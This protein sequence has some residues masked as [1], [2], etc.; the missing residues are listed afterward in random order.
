MI[1]KSA[2]HKID[3]IELM[4]GG[5]G[6]TEIKYFADGKNYKGR[7]RLLAHV[8]LKPGDSIGY[9]VHEGEEEI[10]YILNGTAKYDDNGKETVTVSA[11]DT[12]ITLGG[13]GHSIENI[14]DDVLEFIAV[15]LLYH[16]KES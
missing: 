5:T 2:N 13:E 12:T 15:I 10:Y 16:D 11:G 4:C 6:T 8:T 7:S 9:H 1:E 3:C 14:G